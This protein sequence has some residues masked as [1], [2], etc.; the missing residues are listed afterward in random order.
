MKKEKIYIGDSSDDEVIP[1]ST[2]N[3][4]SGINKIKDDQHAQFLSSYILEEVA[5]SILESKEIS[6]AYIQKKNSTNTI[7]KSNITGTPDSNDIPHFLFGRHLINKHDKVVDVSQ[8]LKQFYDKNQ[9]NIKSFNQSKL[10]WVQNLKALKANL[11]IIGTQDL[12]FDS[13]QVEY[14]KYF[15][16]TD[17]NARFKKYFTALKTVDNIKE[18][19][20][21]KQQ[22]QS[23]ELSTFGKT[24]LTGKDP[25]QICQFFESQFLKTYLEEDLLSIA[26]KTD[27]LKQKLASGLLQEIGYEATLAI[28]YTDDI[29]NLFAQR[30][31]KKFKGLEEC[32][33]T[34]NALVTK[35]YIDNINRES[36]SKINHTLLKKLPLNYYLEENNTQEEFFANFKLAHRIIRSKIKEI[37]IENHRDASIRHNISVSDF[38]INADIEISKKGARTDLRQ[39]PLK[40]QSTAYSSLIS[41]E[42][43]IK[44]STG[45]LLKL[46]L[47]KVIKEQKISDEEITN[48]LVDN[49]DKEFLYKFTDL[50]FHC[51][52]ERNASA[53]LTNAMF[54]EL[55]ADGIYNIQDLP[56]KLPMA[57]TKDESKSS[58]PGAVAG[59]RYILNLLGGEYGE[60]SPYLTK[61]QHYDFGNA[62]DKKGNE[63]ATR[64]TVILLDWLIN[65]SILDTKDTISYIDSNN[66]KKSIKLCE[67]GERI[68]SFYNTLTTQPQNVYAKNTLSPIIK[69]VNHYLADAILNNTTGNKIFNALYQLVKDWYGLELPYLI[70]ADADLKGASDKHHDKSFDDQGEHKTLAVSSQKSNELNNRL[71]SGDD[72]KNQS[73]PL[74]SKNTNNLIPITSKQIIATLKKLTTII[75][76]ELTPKLS[77]ELNSW[78][79]G[80]Y[81]D[82]MQQVL[83][84]SYNENCIVHEKINTTEIIQISRLINLFTK[85][86]LF[87]GITGT[88]EQQI[89]GIRRILHEKYEFMKVKDIKDLTEPEFNTITNQ[90]IQEIKEL[91]QSIKVNHTTSKFKY[92]NYIKEGQDKQKFDAIY[93][94]K[95]TIYGSLKDT[96]LSEEIKEFLNN[97]N[98]QHMII[99]INITDM[100][101][102]AFVISK[103]KEIS[104]IDTM[105][106]KITSDSELNIILQ[107]IKVALDTTENVKYIFEQ[108]IQYDGY[109]CGPFM[110][111]AASRVVREQQNL[112]DFKNTKNTESSI[113]LGESIRTVHKSLL[114]STEV[115]THLTT[116]SQPDTNTLLNTK[117]TKTPESLLIR[118]NIVDITKINNI[119]QTIS[120]FTNDLQLNMENGWTLGRK[121]ISI[122]EAL[123]NKYEFLRAT[124]IS[125]LA[126]SCFNV[127]PWST[128][129]N[130]NNLMKY[131]K[132]D[133]SGLNYPAYTNTWGDRFQIFDGHEERKETYES[134]WKLVKF[135]DSSLNYQALFRKEITQ[136]R[137]EIKEFLQS[138]DNNQHLNIPI[139]VGYPYEISFIINKENVDIDKIIEG[140]TALEIIFQEIKTIL[141]SD[142]SGSGSNLEDINYDFPYHKSLNEYYSDNIIKILNL[143]IKALDLENNVKVL[144]GKYNLL[145]NN[146][147]VDQMLKE[148]TSLDLKDQDK[149]LIPYNIEG[150]HWVGLM[151][152]KNVSSLQINYI[153]PENKPIPEKLLS[154]LSSKTN[155]LELESKISQI[156]VEQQKFNNCGPEVIE[157][158]ILLLTGDRIDDQEDVIPYHS[159]LVENA[160]LNTDSSNIYQAFVN[161]AGASKF[162]VS[163][164]HLEQASFLPIQS[165]FYNVDYVNHQ[166][167]LLGQYHH[168]IA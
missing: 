88:L 54:F 89:A 158:F 134:R 97:S 27:K 70:N 129:D 86:T 4:I 163:C 21:H 34:E 66:E 109:N 146:T 123:L 142:R 166:L 128:N 38:T 19:I 141:K 24:Y 44:S 145:Q 2:S 35:L 164:D 59:A 137:K 13:A 83:L 82:T 1:Y 33:D 63:L 91:I 16:N 168:D 106:G 52:P 127:I 58:G 9:A 37:G 150:K 160:L 31:N 53:F 161:L 6:Y 79:E 11:A 157:N 96:S 154:A 41:N 133:I 85:A 102:T 71:L 119:D 42:L 144:S 111:E 105:A 159:K 110:I 69:S 5:H 92:P 118:A 47:Q 80:W 25:D 126:E 57:I 60:Q 56:N 14:S 23:N 113:N 17:I 107:E 12:N 22:L 10:G 139:K 55:V 68:H 147:D 15:S 78:D 77:Q 29:V 45:Q 130:L 65:K 51:E 7:T 93:K 151:I 155:K 20:K 136:L 131:I 49:R 32:L 48:L 114:E 3:I 43:N 40:G 72:G 64:D 50:L 84:R 120:K 73:Q 149:V 125:I 46:I 36:N 95:N 143:R 167:D 8:L 115:K 122:K 152:T 121:I 61:R 116:I 165:P 112:Q 81:T 90:D 30:N 162:T 62:D 140:N 98:N 76:D 132:V 18:K 75:H 94:L 67:A 74:D 117:T 101:W 39:L 28:D 124:D 135:N 103:D 108:K 153:D 87:Q 99:P 138:S 100:H 104:Y 26:I 148:L 156:I